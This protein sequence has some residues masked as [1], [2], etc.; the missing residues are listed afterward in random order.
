MCV[1]G[2]KRQANEQHAIPD[3]FQS[4][5]K[6]KIP[7]KNQGR[8]YGAEC[9]SAARV[10]RNVD[11]ATRNLLFIRNGNKCV[12]ANVAWNKEHF[13]SIS[14]TERTSNHNQF[15]SRLSH[16][17]RGKKADHHHPVP[18]NVGLPAR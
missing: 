13:M 14:Q 10:P 17:R 9:Y 5:D 16:H 2:S 15:V 12:N 8:S 4:R 1:V 6:K 11:A 18:K 7:R 3:L